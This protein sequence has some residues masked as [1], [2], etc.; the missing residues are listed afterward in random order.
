MPQIML[1][2]HLQIRRYF[3]KICDKQKY[4]TFI[5]LHLKSNIPRCTAWLVGQISNSPKVHFSVDFV[6]ALVLFNITA[7]VF[8]GCMDTLSCMECLC[9]VDNIH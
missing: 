6:I 7:F 8:L 4:I 5:F 9:S 3:N 2:L 1:L